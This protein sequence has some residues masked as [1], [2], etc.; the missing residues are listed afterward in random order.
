MITMGHNVSPPF[1]PQKR[2]HSSFNVPSAPI[3]LP[4]ALTDHP[5]AKLDHLAALTD[6]P[7]AKLDHP[8][9]FIRPSVL[10]GLTYDSTKVIDINLGMFMK[11]LYQYV[12][13]NFLRN[14]P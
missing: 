11:Y 5:T 10:S 3:D 6:H 12:L 13:Q 1:D 4:N 8:A 9:D 14:I 7:T 2:R